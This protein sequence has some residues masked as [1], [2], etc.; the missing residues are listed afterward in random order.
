MSSFG[1]AAPCRGGKQRHRG[2]FLKVKMP[3][4]VRGI[5]SQGEPFEEN[6]VTT[7]IGHDGCKYRSHRHAARDSIVSLEIQS[8][9]A[10]M[11]L[12]PV[13]A[14]VAGVRRSRRHHPEKYLITLELETP[15]NPW[16]IEASSQP[17]PLHDPP[18]SGM[19][20]SVN[21]VGSPALENAGGAKIA[22]ARDWQV[23][24]RPAHGH[25]AIPALVEI[26]EPLSPA[27]FR[28]FVNEFVREAADAIVAEHLPLIRKEFTEPLEA[29][30]REAI[31][32]ESEITPG[33]AAQIRA[34]CLES[35]REVEAGLRGVVEK[36]ANVFIDPPPGKRR[37][38]KRLKKAE[39]P[40]P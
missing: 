6:T 20:V 33:I 35:A 22:Y 2:T 30:I 31:G 11:G 34:A 40:G 25:V 5:D 12:R 23:L 4:I 15:G 24:Q 8:R 36:V 38:S 28:Q 1:A 3:I 27:E 10:R 19:K 18:S 37:T 21:V 7:A 26:E 13:R 16:C 32:A 17:F 9:G 14:R 39:R 29:Y